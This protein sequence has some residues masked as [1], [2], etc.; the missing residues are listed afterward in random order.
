MPSAP[1]PSSPAVPGSGTD[2]VP[3]SGNVFIGIEKYLSGAAINAS[4][5]QIVW[6]Q[7]QYQSPENS[8]L[9]LGISSAQLYLMEHFAQTVSGT[10]YGRSGVSYAGCDNAIN[11][12]SK[13]VHNIGFAGNTLP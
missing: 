8:Y 9:N 11:A 12:R 1:T 4:G 6:C 10:N 5:N 3:L 13:G 7:N 2:E